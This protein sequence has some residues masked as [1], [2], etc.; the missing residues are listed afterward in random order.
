MVHSYSKVIIFVCFWTSLSI[1]KITIINST[2]HYHQR[3]IVLSYAQSVVFDVRKKRTKLPESGG[4]GRCVCGVCVCVCVCVQNRRFQIRGIVW[5]APLSDF[6]WRVRAICTSNSLPL[7]LKPLS[8][9]LMNYCTTK[10]N[11]HISN[12]L[13]KYTLSSIN[14]VLLIHN[15][16]GPDLLRIWWSRPFTTVPRMGGARAG[17]QA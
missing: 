9:L 8:T 1:I 10:I 7:F 17:R 5:G 6:F 3:Y 11:Y 15:H 13:L 2:H 4:P 12:F 14:L 16:Y